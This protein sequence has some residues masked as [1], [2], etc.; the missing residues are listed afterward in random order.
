MLC[1]R[2]RGLAQIGEIGSI[3]ISGAAGTSSNYFAYFFLTLSV[4]AGIFSP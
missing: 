3:A 1:G 4:A 2:E